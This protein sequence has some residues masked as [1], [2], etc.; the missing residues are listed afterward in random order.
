MRKENWLP[1]TM[2][3]GFVLCC[4]GTARGEDFVFATGTAQF[5]ITPSGIEKSFT[6]KRTGKNQ[7]FIGGFPFAAV[8]RHGKQFPVTQFEHRGEL[9]HLTFGE[10]GVF[11]DYRITPGPDY[12]MVELAAIQGDG[13]EKLQLVQFSISLERASQLLGVTWDDNLSICV[14]ELDQRI[15]TV[16]QGSIISAS[17]YPEFPPMQGQRVLIV[18]VPTQQFPSVVQKVERD[19]KLISPLPMID[20]VW[21]KLSPE[22]STNYLFTDLTEANADETI[23]YAKMGGF[24]YILDYSDT[25]S[26]S[27]GSYE[28]NTASFPHGEAGLKSVIDKCHAAGLKVGMHML[29]SVISKRDPIAQRQDAGLLRNSRGDLVQ[30][31]GGYLADLKSPL[32]SALSDRIAGLI[33]GAGFDMIDFDGGDGNYADGPYWYWVGVQQLQIWNRTRRSLIVQGSGIT[34]WTWHIFNRGRCE[35][36][37]AVAP[38]EYLDFQKIPNYWRLFHNSFM[39]SELGWVGLFQDTPDHPATTPDEVEFYAARMLGLGSAIS[40]ETSMAAMKA[41]GR[42][43]EMFKILDSYEQLRVNGTVPAATRQQLLKGEWHMTSAGEFHPVRYDEQRAAVPGEAAV[44]NAFEPQPLKF[45]LQVAPDLKMKD[46][47][48][49]VLLRDT[50]DAGAPQGAMPGALV[51]RIPVGNGGLNGSYVF[52]VGPADKPTAKSLDLTQHRALAVELTVDGAAASGGEVPVLNLQLQA[53]ENTFRDYFV[54]LDFTGTRSIVLAEPG[55]KRTL[56]EF[57]PAAAAYPFKAASYNFNYANIV[58]LNVRWMRYPKQGGVQ[59]RIGAVVAMAE[60]NNKLRDIEIAAGSGKIAIPGEMKTGDYAEYWGSGP[61]RIF[62]KNGNLLRTE[63]AGAA[64]MLAAGENTL[65]IKAAG[66]G[67]VKLTAITM[68]N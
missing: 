36:Y 26:R 34:H 33:D 66:P 56:R 8:T 50:V 52:A 5:V 32:A 59:C 35:D 11:A 43:E 1:L 54:D 10:S 4:A 18:A 63:Q 6:D 16:T 44:K 53:G 31:Y 37:A 48:N 55:T 28:I 14:M 62:D 67:T 58:A 22:V 42:T 45:R 46:S 49:I 68:G 15:D 64:P 7:L 41:N 61:I 38:K 9:Y 12:V 3:L 24:K 60:H 13:I 51:Q 20:G 39:Q 17:V 23:R 30:M 25:W 27:L 57:R 29:T 47:S 19:F 65:S 40:Y 21:A 2:A